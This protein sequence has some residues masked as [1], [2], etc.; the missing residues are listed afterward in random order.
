MN[1]LR[2]L[3]LTEHLLFF[4]LVIDIVGQSTVSTHFNY[5]HD[6]YW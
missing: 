1:E 5:F 4:L 3:M 6:Q 2:L